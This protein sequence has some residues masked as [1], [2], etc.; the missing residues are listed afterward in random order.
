VLL[1]LDN[2]G[3]ADFG[4]RNLWHYVYPIFI[5]V[6]G[7]KW[8]IDYFL[9]RSNHWFLGLFFT[10]FGGLLL[11]D[12]FEV[13]TFYFSDVFKLWPLLIIYIGIVLLKF[14]RGQSFFSVVG[15]ESTFNKSKAA[16]VKNQHFTVGNQSYNQPNWK[17]EPMNIQTLAGDF[18]LDFTKAFIPEKKTPISI[19]SLAGDVHILIPKNINFRIEATVKA[20]EIEVLGNEWGGVN[21][22][23]Q[24]ET[25][26]YEV[27][28]QKLDFVI[29]LKAGSIRVDQV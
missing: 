19:R 7:L 26:D 11:L 10:V 8:L 17:V 18:Y 22:S 2:I 29:K 4:V 20:G 24:Y 12:R 27:A 13:I 15:D 14:G 5:L 9:K 28:Q 21:R 16:G 6:L 1:V 23:Y 25:T 3:V